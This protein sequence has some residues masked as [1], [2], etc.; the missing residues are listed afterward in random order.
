MRYQKIHSQIWNDEKFIS[1]TASQQRLFLYILTCP[2]GNLI[3]YF[4]LKIGYICDDLQCVAKDVKKDLEKLI[5]L[6]FIQYDFLT[7]VIL[8]K[9]FLKH[10]PIT[11]PN[12]VKAAT[13]MLK[14]L[15]N[16]TLYQLFMEVLP[17]VLREVLAKSFRKPSVS[18][19]VSVK[20]E[21][22]KITQNHKNK[23]VPPQLEWIVAYCKERGNSINAQKFMDHYDANGWMRGKNK[24]K[25]W[26][27]TIRT[28]EQ[29]QIN[30]P[31]EQSE[32]L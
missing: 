17:E 31:K 22:P 23:I 29:S 28:W 16:N 9:K 15:P 25:D 7:S 30:K 12:Q 10:N 14:E 32:F 13:K 26:Q 8:V 24:I 3:G 1:L 11:N 4:V 20:E 19:S 18:V 2:H 6:E 21:D 5:E 27:A